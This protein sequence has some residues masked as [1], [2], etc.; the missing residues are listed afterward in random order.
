[1]I[2]YLQ[3]AARTM[4]PEYLEYWGRNLADSKIRILSYESLFAG[5]RFQAGTYVF[6]TFDDVSAPMKRFIDE[7]ALRL[8]D[9]SG[10]RILN[11]PQRVLQ[12]FDLHETLWRE[13][14]SQFRSARAAGDFSSLRFPVFIRSEGSHDGALSPLLHRNDEIETWLGRNLALGRPIDDLLVVEFCET[15]NAEGWYR[16]YAAFSVAGRI[17]PRS[18]N[19]GRAWMLKFGGNEFTQAM[20][21]EEL[22]YVRTNPHEQELREIFAIARTDYGRIDYSMKDGRVQPWEINL[23]PTIGRGLRP[24][25]RY[26]EPELRATREATKEAFYAR[27]NEAWAA[28]ADEFHPDHALVTVH[29]DPAIVAEARASDESQWRTPSGLVAAGVELFK[30]LMKTPLRPLLRMLYRLPK[31]LV[32]ASAG[33]LFRILGRRARQKRARVADRLAEE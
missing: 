30:P 31:R 32:H 6:S 3:P 7:V 4:F 16:K 1:M 13:G 17:A 22:D 33:P 29:L 15:A 20:A 24:S 8:R 12:R 26:I 14:R 25:S 19:Y 10:V 23:N 5:S 21:D 28:V 2:H 18:M 11:D 9:R 27:F